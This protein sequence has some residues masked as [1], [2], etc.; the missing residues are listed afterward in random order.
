M[1]NTDD[2]DQVVSLWQI[3]PSGQGQGLTHLKAIADSNLNGTGSSLRS[4][5]ITGEA[6]ELHGLAFLRALGYEHINQIHAALLQP[7][8][9]LVECFCHGED[10]AHLIAHV[11]HMV[12]AIHPYIC[13]AVRQGQYFVFDWGKK[14]LVA[15]S[16]PSPIVLTASNKRNVP[17][18]MVEA[19]EYVVHIEPYSA[20]QME[21]VVLQW[22]KY[23]R[24]KYQDEKVL[25]Q[26]VQS[27]Q[28]K[29]HQVIDVLKMVMLLV[30]GD[31]RDTVTME[32][33]EKA[34]RMMGATGG[35]ARQVKPPF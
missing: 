15:Y 12:G 14:E 35:N 23:R 22:L 8:H 9:R 30:L 33:V 25:R 13:Q 20:E 29:Y 28:G 3:I 19:V 4:V 17:A 27:E 32:D 18:P 26:I 34:L 6:A 11:E 2:F 16:V 21:L 5:L 31:C 1:G 10:T 24:L 7:A